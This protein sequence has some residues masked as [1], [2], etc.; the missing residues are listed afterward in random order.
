[1]S[2]GC[3]A[4]PPMSHMASLHQV[5]RVNNVEGSRLSLSFLEYEAQR[6][7]GCQGKRLSQSKYLNGRDIFE[8][9]Q[10][11]FSTYLEIPALVQ[12]QYLF[13]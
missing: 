11:T 12:L 2:T 10:I 8:K 4:K 1:M 13:T 3:E 9:E 7:S 5:L 6:L